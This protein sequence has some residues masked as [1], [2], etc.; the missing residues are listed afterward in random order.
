[1][2]DRQCFNHAH[3]RIAKVWG[4]VLDKCGIQKRE[5]NKMYIHPS[6]MMISAANIEIQVAMDIMEMTELSD[7]ML[8]E[9]LQRRLIGRVRETLAQVEDS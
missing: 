2:S 4:R 1:M 3:Q 9:K 5:G 8:E 7:I 6:Q